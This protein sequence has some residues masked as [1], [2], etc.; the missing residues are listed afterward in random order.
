MLKIPAK[1][2]KRVFSPPYNPPRRPA[3]SAGPPKMD[4]T[5]RFVFDQNFDRFL[6]SIFDRFWVVL[7]HQ[8]G[9]MFLPFGDQVGPS[10]VQNASCKLIFIRNVN[11]HEILCFPILLGHNGTQD[12][13]PNGP[14][15]AQD[16]SKRC[17]E[18]NFFVVE[19]QRKF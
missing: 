14:R 7:G 18:S 16:G 13:L 8:V 6:I 1:L 19:N 4:H 17:L 3:H 5:I 2:R 12:G 11:V 15:S 9:V 10:S